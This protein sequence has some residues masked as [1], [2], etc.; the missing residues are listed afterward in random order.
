[1]NKALV[2]IIFFLLLAMAIMGVGGV[3]FGTQMKLS[4]KVVPTPI[5]TQPL[6]GNDRDAYGCIPSAGYSWC[7]VKQKCLRSWEE[8]CEGNVTTPTVTVDETETIKTIVKQ[9]LVAKHGN[10]AN[11]LTISVSAI[12]GNYAKG[13]AGGSGG[14]GMWFA[15]KVNGVWKLVWDGNGTIDCDSVNPYPDLPTIWIPE[16]YNAGIGKM[17]PR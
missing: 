11:E 3:L 14:G 5:P 1:M 10:T 2:G 13:G 15:V 7:E 12:Q 8:T 6:V 17:I 16:C 4:S 9:L